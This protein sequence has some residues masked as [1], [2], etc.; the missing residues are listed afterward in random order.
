[1]SAFR[2]N[3]PYEISGGPGH[4]LDAQRVPL[5]MIGATDGVFSWGSLDTDTLRWTQFVRH[6]DAD[7]TIVLDEGQPVA[8]FDRDDARVLAGFVTLKLPTWSPEGTTYQMEISNAWWYYEKLGILGNV[9]W[10]GA[11]DDERA[12][13]IAPEQD[14]AITIRRLIDRMT[15]Q[16]VPLRSGIIST[17]FTMSQI[18]FNNDLAARGLA[19]ILTLLP[20]AM[21]RV[22]YEE[23]GL[24]VL[25]VIRRDEAEAVV[26][27]LGSAPDMTTAFQLREKTELRPDY[28]AVDY[29]EALADGTLV[30]KKLEAGTA[31]AGVLGKQLVPFSGPGARDWRPPKIDKVKLRTMVASDTS[32]DLFY[33][34]HPELAALEKMLLA[35]GALVPRPWTVLTGT[36]SIR[37]PTGDGFN[38]TSYGSRT[39]T[40]IQEGTPGVML[41]Y[42]IVE[43]ELPDW[44]AETGIQRQRVSLTQRFITSAANSYIW[45]ADLVALADFSYEVSGGATYF[46]DLTIEFD[47]IAVPYAVLTDVAKPSDLTFNKPPRDLA[48]SL[49][50]VQQFPAYAGGASIGAQAPQIPRPGQKVCAIG[51]ERK[52]ETAGA[53]VQGTQLDLK[54]GMASVQMGAPARISPQNLIDRFLRSATGKIVEL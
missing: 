39:L 3:P 12:I 49:W 53:L 35:G 42:A 8:V 54:T 15:A 17:G 45:Q 24:P 25:D 27:H 23:D 52:W 48:D 2:Y 21:T 28:V 30:P 9:Q 7:Q 46:A 29:V 6:E 43:G 41:G 37:V 4:A 40:V 31:T 18:T 26:L 10:E 16:G 38:I 47:A 20:D 13:M 32:L 14:L 51:G 33:R 36:W 34:L 50:K 5:G 44:W 1:M 22:R 19:D 11:E